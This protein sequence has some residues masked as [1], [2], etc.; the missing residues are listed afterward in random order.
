MKLALLCKDIILDTNHINGAASF[1]RRAVFLCYHFAMKKPLL[2]LVFFAF[3]TPALAYNPIPV[4]PTEQYE[5]LKIDGDPY[6]EHDFLGTLADYPETFELKTDVSMT[7]TA[8]VFQ[9]STGTPVPFGLMFVRQNDSDGGVTEVARASTSLSNWS[10][11]YEQGLGITLLQGSELR[12]DIGP[13]TYHLEVN[14]PDNKG[15]YML[16]IGEEPA[17]TSYFKTLAHVARIQYHFG[18]T[19]LHLLLSSYVFYPLG[20]LGIL[21]STGY[22]YRQR[23]KQK[24]KKYV[25]FSD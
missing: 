2:V 20:I 19:P 14:T 16:V 5:V 18:Y 17:Q 4:H 11:V 8:A 15:D 6:I 25:R 21:F 7:F 12:K 1:A 9:R 24:N 22:Y 3:A 23:H 10:K 13:G